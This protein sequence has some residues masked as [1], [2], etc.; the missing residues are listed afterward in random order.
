MPR[1]VVRQTRRGGREGGREGGVDDYIFVV[2]QDM[3]KRKGSTGRMQ[4]EL[5]HSRERGR[6]GRLGVREE[7]AR[8]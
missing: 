4:G 3:A 7:A 6:T 5:I 1:S 8:D 2:V